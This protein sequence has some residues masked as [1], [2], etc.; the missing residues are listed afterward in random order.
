VTRFTEL[1]GCRHPIQQAAM[2]GIATPELAAA[3]SNAGGLGML[4]I[5]RPSLATVKSQLDELE[6]LTDRPVGV[7]LI[8]EFLDGEILAE[9]VAR[10]PVIEFFWGWP[11]PS[12]VPADRIVGWQVGSVD[13]AIAAVDAGCHYVVAQGIEAGGHVRGTVELTDLV[14]AV[15]DALGDGTAI[16]AAGGIG[17]ATDVRAALAG[18]ADA[19]RVGSRFVATHESA[20]HDRYVERLA[21]SGGADT[22]LSEA[23]WVGWPDAPHRVLTAAVDASGE[24]ADV[25]GHAT[26][27]DGT[28][29]PI[30][31]F[32]VSPPTRAFTGA[33]DAMALYAGMGIDAITG[34]TTADRVVA[35]LL[36]IPDEGPT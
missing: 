8:V 6:S 17:T 27:P 35:E 2:S 36:D 16:V 32:F 30:P 20:A 3:V 11:E 28:T 7:G 34:R 29:Q 15:R 13:E 4:G 19:V 1:V 25:I 5:G 26:L 24:A 12:I 22:E 18:G 9:V 23:F 10:L 14:T 21:E 33:I 31:R